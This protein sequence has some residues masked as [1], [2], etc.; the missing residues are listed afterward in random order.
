MVMERTGL[1]PFLLGIAAVALAWLGQRNLPAGATFD[2]WL[3]FGAAVIIFLAA[4][5]PAHFDPLQ[6][7]PMRRGG[8]R[9]AE[10]WSVRVAA[11][12]FAIALLLTLNAAQQFYALEPFAP[13][14]W[15]WQLAAIGSAIGGAFLLDRGVRLRAPG[16]TGPIREDAVLGGH[17]WLKV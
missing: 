17:S 13:L 2:A 15:W 6:K 16:E 14:A 5:W 12:L 7:L 8:L 11:G 4:F 10:A 9:V 1:R 3:F